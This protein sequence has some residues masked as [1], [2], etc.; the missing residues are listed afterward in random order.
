MLH[1]DSDGLVMILSP[2]E[3]VFH[4]DGFQHLWQNHNKHHIRTNVRD[5]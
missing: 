1:I 3:E 5:F 4:Y 2:I